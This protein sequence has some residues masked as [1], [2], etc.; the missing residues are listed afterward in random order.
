L[1][2]KVASCPDSF[3][4]KQN[5]ALTVGARAT[6]HRVHFLW[7]GDAAQNG[8]GTYREV[9]E[10]ALAAH[11]LRGFLTLWFSID[12]SFSISPISCV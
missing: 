2:R 6:A 8:E 11:R 1:R 10:M 5:P 3:R 9:C 7:M 12:P 4:A